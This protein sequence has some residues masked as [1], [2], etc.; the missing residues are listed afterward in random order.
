MDKQKKKKYNLHYRI[1]KQGYQ[2]KT[3]Q[4]TI[5]IKHD[6]LKKSKQVECLI[7]EYGYQTQLYF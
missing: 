6:E 4:K 5:L 3:A 2:L 1:R 7:K